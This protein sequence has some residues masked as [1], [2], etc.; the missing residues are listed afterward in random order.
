MVQRLIKHGDFP[1]LP[2]PLT[3]IFAYF[4]AEGKFGRQGPKK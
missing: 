2:L 4:L 3:T 1:L